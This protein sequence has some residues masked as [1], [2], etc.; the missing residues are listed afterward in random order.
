VHCV[1]GT[2]GAGFR[3][4]LRLPPTTIIVTKGEDPDNPGYSAFEGHTPDGRSFLADLFDRG[5][6][7]LYVGGLATDYCV[8]HSV[9]DARAKGL[10]V[11]VLEDAVAGV[12]A[13]PGDSSGALAEMREKGADVVAGTSG[14]MPGS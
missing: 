12:D 10:K 8:K 4:G 14:L 5:V 2:E 9:L 6:D 11:T 3:N 13:R 7:H 1:A